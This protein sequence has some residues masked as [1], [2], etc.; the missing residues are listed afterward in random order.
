MWPCL[1]R[2]LTPNVCLE[3]L[4]TYH[5]SEIAPT[6]VGAD[7]AALL[8]AQGIH[9]RFAAGSWVQ[10]SGDDGN[11]FWLIRRGN[12]AACRYGEDGGLTI[13]AVL[14]P[15]DLFGELAYFAKTKRQADAIAQS[16][17]DLVWIGP[18][19]IQQLLSTQPGFAE[20]LL[21]SLASQLRAALDRIDIA[22]HGKGEARLAAALIEM[23]KSGAQEAQDII[24]TQQELADYVGISRV[25]TGAILTKLEQQG[26]IKRGYGKITIV[27]LN[28]LA[29]A[30]AGR[31]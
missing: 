16:D 22:R 23:A 30:A 17:A 24:C 19:L 5:S 20:T 8:T 25:Q 4:R 18:V 28:N 2:Q 29:A 31:I 11:G 15:G 26:T 21:R 13:F 14:G 10:H 27:A 12:V 6:T 3:M 9:R 1:D 7:I